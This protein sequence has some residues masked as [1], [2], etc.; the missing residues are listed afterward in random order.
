MK[1]RKGG[2][3]YRGQA[4]FLFRL[5]PLGRTGRAENY[6]S[7]S[8]ALPAQELNLSARYPLVSQEGTSRGPVG[9][10]PATASIVVERRADMPVIKK[11]EFGAMN[12]ATEAARSVKSKNEALKELERDMY[13][14]T[15]CGPREAL[16]AT[17]ERFHTLWFGNQ[18]AVL[19]LTEEKLLKVTA[20]FKA[21][22]Y[23]SYKNYL[24]RVKDAHVMAGNPWTD[25]LQRVAQKCSRSA[26]RG[27]A[28][29]T[30]SEPFELTRVFAS[31]TD[32]Q[33]A[34][35]DGGPMHPASMIVCATFFMLR[36]IEASGVQINDV[37]FGHN[38]VTLCL[39]VSKVD[40]RAKGA[41]RTWQCICDSFS[42]CPFH[43]L[44][45]HFD[46]L[47]DRSEL[48][49]LFPS[50]DGSFCTKE[51][52]VTTIRTLAKSAGQQVQDLSGGWLIS[53]HTFRITGARLLA[54]LGL[55]AITIQ[56]LGRWG[57]DAVLS[58]LAEA[59]LSNLADKLRTPLH[60]SRLSEVLKSSQNQMV[61]QVHDWV[62]TAALLEEQR[63]MKS[64]LDNLLLEFNRLK[65][66]TTSLGTD[67]DG[68]AEIV[69]NRTPLE[70]WRVG[71]DQSK[72]MHRALVSLASSPC[73]WIT[74]CGWKFAGKDH[75]VTYRTE[76]DAEKSLCCKLCPKCH[77]HLTNSSVS[78][79]DSS[80]D[81]E[82]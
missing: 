46:R 69:T 50:R 41:K 82:D 52:V 71:N 36:E 44:R 33:D 62:G 77:K 19:P 54:T 65:D 6:P 14:R 49:P 66:T 67:L 4:P 34:I 38:S 10:P 27:L 43:V 45:R 28:G 25:L 7:S 29:P 37:T 23:K 42:I 9:S 53:G 73:N 63:Q 18:V 21:G 39:P 57:S 31:A 1:A 32:L 8:N 79:S 47:A 16:L 58:Y 59:P 78:S 24:S 13:A 26:L 51:G 61:E 30:R 72:V 22:G 64:Q 80:S 56:L 35:C 11:R 75:A 74:M 68:V 48:S 15:S 40:W 20:L 55:D 70:E 76:S 5:P 17:W 12:L 60:E 81:S 3:P 2:K